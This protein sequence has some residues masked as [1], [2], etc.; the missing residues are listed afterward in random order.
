[1]ATARPLHR[2]DKLLYYSLLPFASIIV[3]TFILLFIVISYVSFP[4]IRRYGTSIL[5]ATRWAPNEASPESSVYGLLAPLF[6]TLVSSTIAVILALPV[7]VSVVL[8]LEEY[9]P[10]RL[11]EVIGSII[12]LMAGLPT[13]VYGLWGLEVLA[14]MLRKH[15]YS[16][17]HELL[18]FIP[19]FSCRPITGFNLA[20]AGVLLAIMIL[21][22]M[23]AVARDAYRSIPF[24]YREAALAIGATRYEYARIMLGLARPGIIAAAL[25]GF[26]RAAG[27]TVAVA[28]VVGNTPYV[29]ACLFKPAYTV[30]S[31]IANQFANANLYPYMMNV[32][33]FGGLLLLLIGM[34]ANTIAVIMIEKVRKRLA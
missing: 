22:Y 33:F 2:S 27:E 34:V 28:L 12:E 13:I 16:P 24:I 9:A 1:M 7:A 20:T 6:G 31:L 14:P 3:A 4:A 19:L 25:L 26:G 21:P 10:Q 29:G 17:L 18:G 8:V 15:V 32:L 11:R 5:T 23:V 30:S